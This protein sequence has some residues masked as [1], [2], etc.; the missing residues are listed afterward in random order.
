M[1][2]YRCD[3]SQNTTAKL[4]EIVEDLKNNYHYSLTNLVDLGKGHLFV[5]GP[6]GCSSP[7]QQSRKDQI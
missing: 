3:Y 2:Y 6:F 5:V 1:K 7:D 4:E